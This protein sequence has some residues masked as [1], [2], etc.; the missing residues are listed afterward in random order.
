MSDE[1][2]CSFERRTQGNIPQTPRKHQDLTSPTQDFTKKG[3]T[4]SSRQHRVIQNPQEACTVTVRPWRTV[5][6]RSKHEWVAS[7]VFSHHSGV[8]LILGPSTVREIPDGEASDCRKQKAQ[9]DST[10]LPHPVPT[11]KITGHGQGVTSLPGSRKQ[12]PLKIS[13]HS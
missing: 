12:K 2:A 7:P 6:F 5:W 1:P 3:N 11:Y 4:L 13:S 9:W 10:S 8:H